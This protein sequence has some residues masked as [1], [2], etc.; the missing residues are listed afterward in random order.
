MLVTSG[1]I[2][3]ERTPPMNDVRSALSF[4]C[5]ALSMQLQRISIVF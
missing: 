1:I 4:L 3:K 2:A 5:I